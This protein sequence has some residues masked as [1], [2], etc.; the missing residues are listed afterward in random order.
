MITTAS[1]SR[2]CWLAKMN[3]A[4]AVISRNPAT[5]P[6][7][8]QARSSLIGAR[9]AATAMDVAVTD[10]MRERPAIQTGD[11]LAWWMQR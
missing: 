11:P 1:S 3:R 8:M 9:V 2:P 6:S 10:P 5:M 7:A 4:L